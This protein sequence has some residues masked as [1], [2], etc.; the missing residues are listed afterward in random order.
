MTEEFADEE[1]EK[2]LYMGSGAKYKPS[3][4]VSS[5]HGGSSAYY[6]PINNRASSTAAAVY[7]PE[8]RPNDFDNDYSQIKSPSPTRGAFYDP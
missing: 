3:D 7:T 4:R 6:E 8:R 5:P 1:Y 2:I